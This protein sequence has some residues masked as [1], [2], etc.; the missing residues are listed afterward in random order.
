M[1]TDFLS[2]PPNLLGIDI[3]SSSIKLIELGRKNGQYTVQTYAVAP[4]VSED[5]MDGNKLPMEGITQALQD[6]LKQANTRTRSAALALPVSESISKLITLPGPLDEGELLARVTHEADQQLPYKLDE[7]YWDF[8]VQGPHKGCDDK[9]DVLLV[10]SRREYVEDRVAAAERAGLKVDIMDMETYALENV[11]NYLIKPESIA[12]TCYGIINIGE[13]TSQISII[14][15]QRTVYAS[16]LRFGGY[17][18]T[19]AL[20]NHYAIDRQEAVSL[21]H[22][23]DFPDI[24]HATVLASVHTRFAEQLERSLKTYAALSANPGLHHLYLCGGGSLLPGLMDYLAGYFELA[25]TIINPL[26]GLHLP[27]QTD[28]L[29]LTNQAPLYTTALG[30]A[31]RRYDP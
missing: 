22:A 7:L 29:T 31:L 30:L 3:G 9:L 12:G 11:F 13:T 27:T 6:A 20:Q 5:G 1:I 16:E 26:S 21:K 10:A 17:Q 24:L 14:S 19:V 4:L 2:S 18:A 15:D 28:S 25:V 8:T 23:G